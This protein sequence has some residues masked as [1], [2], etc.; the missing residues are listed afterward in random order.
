MV[1][2]MK[3]VISFLLVVIILL[4]IIP[5]EVIAVD[6]TP[7]ISVNDS[8]GQ[9]GSLIDVT[10]S[11]K[12]NPG[13]ASTVLNF[14]FAEELTLVGYK[15]GDAFSNL[16][17]TAPAEL[18]HGEMKDSA[19]FAWMASEVE[20]VKDGTVLTLTFRVSE[21]A[22]LDKDCFIS[23][24]VGASALEDRSKISISSENGYL[25]TINYTPG[26]VDKSGEVDMIDV[27]VLCQYIVDACKFNPRGY[28]I[29]SIT[30]SNEEVQRVIDLSG[31]NIG[32]SDVSRIYEDA[33]NVDLGTECDM[34]DV[35]CIYR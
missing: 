24:T 32:I 28:R 22:E 19:N 5:I 16:S 25:K 1:I 6:A 18:K 9:P 31:E 35:L 15:N 8:W 14:S 11:I 4:A 17:L 29:A 2:T 20:E 33:A 26:D 23:V 21:D 34:I 3:K 10:V 13:I 7:V 12:N 30:M 27:L